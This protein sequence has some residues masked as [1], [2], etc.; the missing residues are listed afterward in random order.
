[1][2]ASLRRLI[3][4]IPDRLLSPVNKGLETIRIDSMPYSKFEI[5]RSMFDVN[6]NRMAKRNGFAAV[7]VKAVGNGDVQTFL[8]G[9][10]VNGGYILVFQNCI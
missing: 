2:I 5:G 6:K 3:N 1:M 7:A 9:N 4:N 10:C 8:A